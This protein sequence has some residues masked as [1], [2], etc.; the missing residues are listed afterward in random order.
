[1][2]EHIK[3]ALCT[4]VAIGPR[5][6]QES[7]IENGWED[8]D[9]S[10]SGEESNSVSLNVK[11]TVNAVAFQKEG[12]EVEAGPP[13][14]DAWMQECSIALSP[15]SELM[16]IAFEQKAVFLQQKW[17]PEAKDG[18]ESKYHIVFKGM[19]NQEEGE[20]I[21]CAVCVPLASQKRSSHGAPDW[22]CVV[23][24]FTSGYVR[25]YTE[26]KLGPGSKGELRN[27]LIQVAVVYICNRDSMNVP[28]P[29]SC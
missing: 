9:W 28:K 12:S 29:S 6:S 4:Y 10:W 11:T 24:G 23:L 22:T 20:C 3:L 25:M 16:V 17:D 18:V 1:M 8:A 19:L 26:I 27:L 5:T 13:D 21:T 14:Q 15:T 2:A 7:P